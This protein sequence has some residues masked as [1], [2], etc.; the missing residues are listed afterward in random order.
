MTEDELREYQMWT[1][2]DLQE[3]LLSTGKITDQNWLDNYLRPKFKEAF[4]H[5]A[6][7]AEDSLYKSSSVFE[8]Y[9]LDFVID[10]DTNIWFIECNPSPQ[11]VGTSERKTNFLVQTV[12]DMFE[13]Q[14]AYLR[15]RLQRVHKFIKAME[16][17]TLRGENVDYEQLRKD[18]DKIN[19]NKLEPEFAIR[20]ENSFT[21]IMDKNL[22]GADAYF[23]NLKKECV[24]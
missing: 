7:M 23:G 16:E 13:I 9:G 18:F 11:M 19:M 8:M 21:L 12:S 17:K 1:M 15:S 3:Y 20:P 14:Y 10:E 24:I 22:E 2:E 6:R 5:I 4:I